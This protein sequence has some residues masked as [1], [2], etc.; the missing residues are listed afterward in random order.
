MAFF[1]PRLLFGKRILTIGVKAFLSL[2]WAMSEIPAGINRA[3]LRPRRQNPWLLIFG[4]IAAVGLVVGGG[5][6]YAANR[7]VSEPPPKAVMR[8]PNGEVL[9]DRYGQ[10]D[11]PQTVAIARQL[12][13]QI[14]L[15]NTRW[16]DDAEFIGEPIA[17]PTGSERCY[18]RVSGK[19]KLA[20]GFGAHLTHP[21]IAEV[22]LHDPPLHDWRCH[23]LK[24][25]DTVVPMSEGR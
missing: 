19:V 6:Y 20:N 15:K 5:A 21:Y 22:C 8:G 12:A 9:S 24:I 4:P 13:K 3:A 16:P 11:D 14:V 18:L 10:V 2:G 7:P 25:G 1:C 17:E 23:Y